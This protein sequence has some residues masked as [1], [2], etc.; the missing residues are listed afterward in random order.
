MP[1]PSRGDRV[2]VTARL[3]RSYYSK[4]ERYV[5]IT[6]ATKTDFITEAVTKEL[7]G[8]DI[9]NLDHQQERLPLTA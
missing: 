6:G 9:E 1:R 3:P 7:D 8:V 5:Q 4:L 2:V